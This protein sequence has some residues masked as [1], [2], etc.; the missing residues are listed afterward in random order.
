MSFTIISQ[1]GAQTLRE[2]EC[3]TRE[4]YIAV[5]A[6]RFGRDGRPGVRLT[7]AH[8]SGVTVTLNLEAD[9]VRHLAAELLASAD[10]I[11]AAVVRSKR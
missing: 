7:C 2:A 9:L 5:S 3:A 10:A 1:G 8:D 11:D 4:R 6:E